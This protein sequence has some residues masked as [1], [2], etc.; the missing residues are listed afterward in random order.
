MLHHLFAP[1]FAVT[2]KLQ[3]Q[4]PSYQYVS[5]EQRKSIKTIHELKLLPLAPREKPLSTVSRHPPPPVPLTGGRYA[6]Y[7]NAYLPWYAISSRMV[8]YPL[9][10]PT[11]SIWYWLLSPICDSLALWKLLLPI[12]NAHWSRWKLIS[13]VCICSDTIIVIDIDLWYI[14][15][16]I[17]HGEVKCQTYP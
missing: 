3:L 8:F 1:Y 7:W 15:W 10:Q 9:Y 5:H 11:T 2:L 16:Y 14:L 12:F 13:F 4:S 6:S 17:F